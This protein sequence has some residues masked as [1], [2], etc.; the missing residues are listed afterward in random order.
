[1]DSLEV[2]KVRKCGTRGNMSCRCND[3]IPWLAP[4]KSSCAHF[5]HPN[6]TLQRN[7][8]LRPAAQN[9]T[10][11]RQHRPLRSC[12]DAPALPRRER[13]TP[14]GRP[15]APP[16][17]GRLCGLRIRRRSSGTVESTNLAATTTPKTPNNQTGA[18]GAQI[19]LLSLNNQIGV[20]GAQI[21]L[22]RLFEIENIK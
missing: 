4:C 15:A 9:A 14:P 2:T 21:R 22:L 6:G 10:W 19:R 11:S 20:C 13:R 7:S 5:A 16:H 3:G 12:S 17:A 18:C 8:Q 1:M